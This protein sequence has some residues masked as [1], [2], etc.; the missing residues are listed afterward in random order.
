MK[1]TIAAM[2][3]AGSSIKNIFTNNMSINIPIII[4]IIP[5][6]NPSIPDN[7]NILFS[8]TIIIISYLS[9]FQRIGFNPIFLK[10]FRIF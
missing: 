7:I 1:Y 8:Q 5:I 9:F 2:M 4:N 10:T 6:I 3:I